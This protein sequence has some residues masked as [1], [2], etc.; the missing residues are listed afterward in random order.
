MRGR[1]QVGGEDEG[2]EDVVGGG[3]EDRGA[4]WGPVGA[5]E[6]GE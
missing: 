3:G 5:F 2:A 4:V 6:V 1:E